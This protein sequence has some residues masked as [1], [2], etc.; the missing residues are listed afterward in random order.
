VTIIDNVS[1]VFKDLT[2]TSNSNYT[3]IELTE[4]RLETFKELKEL[5]EKYKSENKNQY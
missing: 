4:L 2:L 5:S 1:G 3:I